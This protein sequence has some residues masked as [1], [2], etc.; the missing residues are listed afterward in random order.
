MHKSVDTS[1]QYLKG[2]GPQKAKN[3]NNQ[4]LKI[5]EDLLYHFPRR[6]E[7][8]TRFITIHKMAPGESYTIKVQVLAVGQ[9]RSF[10]RRGFS[11]LEVAVGDETG[12]IS[13]IWFNQPYLKNYFK[14]GQVLILYGKVQRYGPNLQ[15]NSPEFEIV[16]DGQDDGSLHTGRIVPLYSVPEGTTQRFFRRIMRHALDDYVSSV[17]EFLPYDIRLR[18]NLLNLAKS[19]VQIHFP[20]DLSTQKKAYERLAFDEFFIFQLPVALRKTKQK[21]K[22]GIAHVADGRLCRR[23]TESLSFQLTPSQRD[24]L[25]EIRHDMAEA[26]VMHRLLQGDVGSGKTVVATIASLLAI[27]G[28]YQVVMLVPT[29]ILA[30]Q[31]YEKISAQ[32]NTLNTQEKVVRLGLLVSGIPKKEKDEVL[33]GIQEGKINFI[34]GTHALLEEKVIFHRVGLVIID[35]QH[36]FGVA[37]RALLPQKGVNPDVLIM[38]ATP[39]PRTLAI[40]VY[41]DLDVSVLRELPPGRKP[42]LTQW[43]KEEKREWIYDFIRGEVEL[44]HQA[45]IIHP[46]IEDSYSL[47]LASAKSRYAELKDR[48]FKDL[49]VGLIHGKLKESEQDKVMAAFKKGEIKILVATSV[50]E[51]GIDIPLATVMV[52]ENA[53]RFGLSQLHQLRGRIGRGGFESTC[54]LVSSADSKEAQAR[55]TALVKYSDGFQ[56][57]EEDLRIRGPGEFFGSRQH[58]LTELRIANPLTQLQLL[59]KAREEAFRLVGSDPSLTDRQHV[60]VREQLLRRFPQYDSL[61]MVG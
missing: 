8:R 24:V 39:I 54:I 42:I 17:N 20:D 31:Q 5:I 56:I 53:E 58:G 19:I 18:H 34:V 12:R 27:E 48:V 41:G 25:T 61:V 45:Y 22:S 32:V 40:T 36:K 49:K 35:E 43:V 52:I 2:I 23:F 15:M 33:R 9:R 16:G 3:F 13:C 38:T 55:L 37:Q 50:L 14:V 44:G 51:V 57:A 6:Y 46:I 28:G 21:E 4:G 30:K 60:L 59:K 47:D 11:I 29:E 1:L 7:D 10:R 26:S